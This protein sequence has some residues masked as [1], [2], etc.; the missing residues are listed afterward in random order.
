M[1]VGTKGSEDVKVSDRVT[2]NWH[3][4][5]SRTEILSVKF[6]GT[7]LSMKGL[8]YMGGIQ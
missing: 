4:C 8:I 6:C 3:V 2:I 1:L 7:S 5:S